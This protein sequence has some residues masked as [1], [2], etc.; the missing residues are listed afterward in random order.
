MCIH[1]FREGAG[2]VVI[3]YG[4]EPLCGH[5]AGNWSGSGLLAELKPVWRKELTWIPL[6][7]SRLRKPKLACLRE[8]Y[9]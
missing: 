2:K 4:L 9:R 3:L 5:Q 6:C 8:E 7:K 1:P